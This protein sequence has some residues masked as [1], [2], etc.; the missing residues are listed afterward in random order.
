MA[1]V[2]EQNNKPG[3]GS[4]VT[5]NYSYAERHT[6]TKEN[7]L[8]RSDRERNELESQQSPFDTQV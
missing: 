6:H 7:L 2:T 8:T 5:C 1:L 4:F 3:G